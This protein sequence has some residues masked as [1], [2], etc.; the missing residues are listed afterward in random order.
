[1]LT[2]EGHDFGWELWLIMVPAAITRILAVS[3]FLHRSLLVGVVLFNEAERKVSLHY[4]RR[5]S[6]RA[7]CVHAILVQ[8]LVRIPSEDIAVSALGTT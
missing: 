4:V 8:V 3:L 5:E 2:P 7:L 1:M 6:D